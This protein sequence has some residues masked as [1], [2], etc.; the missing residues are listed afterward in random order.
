MDVFNN[1]T[2]V[3]A[4][5]LT[6]RITPRSRISIA[7]AC[8]SIYAY[9]ELKKE[10]EN[11]EELRFIFTS[12]TFVAEKTA[13]ERREF[14]IS[15]LKHEK[16]IYGTEF[17]SPIEEREIAGKKIFS[18]DSGYLIACFDTDVTEEVVTAIAKEKPFYAVF[19]D[20]SM[21]TDSVMTNFEQIFETY[22]PNTVR[23][24]L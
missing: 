10:L 5:D 17:S 15:R 7:A 12:P 1:T 16:S 8:F 18:V 2:K 14:Y 21:A 6:Q 20:S 22:S 9:R 11:C 19:R 4:D 24:V 23:K 3:V 13:R